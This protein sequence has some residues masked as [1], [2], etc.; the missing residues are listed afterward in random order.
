MLTRRTTL[1]CA[2]VKAGAVLES[3]KRSVLKNSGAI[4]RDFFLPFP[5]HRKAS[6]ISAATSKS[7]ETLLQETGEHRARRIILAL[8]RY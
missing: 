5:R 8:I 4:A 6:R 3:G 2:S 7:I 1:Q